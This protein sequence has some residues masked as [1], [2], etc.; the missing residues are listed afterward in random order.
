[1]F[2]SEKEGIIIE[3]K[4]AYIL[5][6]QE[7]QTSIK[8]LESDFFFAIHFYLGGFYSIYDLKSMFQ[9]EQSFFRFAHKEMTRERIFSL[10]NV[11]P[12]YLLKNTPNKLRASFF[13]SIFEIFKEDKEL[14]RTIKLYIE[15]NSNA[16]LTAKQLFL[17]RNSLQYRIDKFVEKTGFDLKSFPN[18]LIV[19]LACIDFEYLQ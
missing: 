13:A 12:L 16:S 7:L 9:L 18:V 6:L 15:N 2:S 17:H 10:T 5:S 4:K 14:R 8:T 11:L 1:M 19:Y 3:E